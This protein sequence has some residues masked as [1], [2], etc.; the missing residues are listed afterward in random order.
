MRNFVPSASEKV[1]LRSMDNKFSKD[2]F[3]SNSWK[4]ATCMKLRMSGRIYEKK[5][6]KFN[7]SIGESF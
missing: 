1:N 2:I 4:Y 6:K 3:Y 5:E 7:Q